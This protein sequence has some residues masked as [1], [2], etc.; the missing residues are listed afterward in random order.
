MRNEAHNEQIRFLIHKM[1]EETSGK[2]CTQMNVSAL[3]IY[4]PKAFKSVYT[5]YTGIKVIVTEV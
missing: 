1:K 3:N 2:P 5:D 4:S